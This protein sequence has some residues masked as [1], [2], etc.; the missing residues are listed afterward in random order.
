VIQ[1]SK[2]FTQR[3]QEIDSALW[4]NLAALKASFFD[5]LAALILCVIAAVS[6]AHAIVRVTF[7]VLGLLIWSLALLVVFLYWLRDCALARSSN[8]LRGSDDR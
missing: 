6:L 2:I 8:P 3:E 1:P 5:L 4:S 7:A